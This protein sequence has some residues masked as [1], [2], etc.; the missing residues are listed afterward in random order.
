VAAAAPPR[1][2]ERE[3]VD[4]FREAFEATHRAPP[5]EAHLRCFGELA[6]EG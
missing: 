4:L 1:L 3:P 5:S 6:E 2:A